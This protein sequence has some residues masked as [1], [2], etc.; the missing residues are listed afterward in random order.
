MADSHRYPRWFD[1]CVSGQANELSRLPT[2]ALSKQSAA[3]YTRDAAGYDWCF[4]RLPAIPGLAEL[5]RNLVADVHQ[6]HPRRV[7]PVLH[8]LFP[9]DVSVLDARNLNRRFHSLF[10]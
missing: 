9:R 7:A 5:S 3:L 10:I 4:H 8:R 2:R 1:E 6:C